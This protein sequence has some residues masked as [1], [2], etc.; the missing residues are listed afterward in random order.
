MRL[1]LKSAAAVDA[2]IVDELLAAHADA[3]T[4]R[5]SP[6]GVARAKLTTRA[7]AS[8]VVTAGSRRALG[9]AHVWRDGTVARALLVVRPGAWAAHAIG[10]ALASFAETH[11]A[12]LGVTFI[13]THQC[14]AD[15]G[16]GAVLAERSYRIASTILQMR[17]DLTDPTTSA[18]F[19]ATIAPDDVEVTPFDAERDGD[20]LFAVVHEVFPDENDDEKAWWRDH[21]DN[22]TRLFDP[23]LWFVARRRLDGHLVGFALGFR[24]VED[25][26]VVGYLGGLGVRRA[27][28][29]RGIGRALFI[30][31]TDAFVE[32]GFPSMALSVASGNRTGALSLYRRFG[33]TEVPESTEWAKELPVASA[34]Y[35]CFT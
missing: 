19:T 21:R 9:F 24:R 20:W 18:T 5:R 26:R 17:A 25:G 10:Q 4:G 28:R 22:P 27:E 14:A 31:V 15:T 30:A 6:T 33:M 11:A 29:G 2:P 3:H 35:L 34:A 8:A 13:K 32:A 7:T 16:L 1:Y 12:K 23:A